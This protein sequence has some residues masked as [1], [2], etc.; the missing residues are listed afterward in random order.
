MKKTIILT[1]AAC[2]VFAT[3][4][5]A[6]SSVFPTPLGIDDAVAIDTVTTSLEVTAAGKKA[7]LIVTTMIWGR[8]SGGIELSIDASAIDVSGDIEVLAPMATYEIYDI[9]CRGAVDTAIALGYA[10]CPTSASAATGM[11]LARCV[12][13]SGVAFAVAGTGLVRR[14]YSYGC[15]SSGRTITMTGVSGTTTCTGGTD[16]TTD[17]SG[18][19]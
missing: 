14:G 12:T 1:W 5:A 8:A 19:E 2:A 6:Q 10:A 18:L 3:S 11:T 9:I 16:A 17:T 4:L 13:R 15:P 7:Q